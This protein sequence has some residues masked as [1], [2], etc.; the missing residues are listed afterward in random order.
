MCILFIY[1]VS[2]LGLCVFI[3]NQFSSIIS[4]SMFYASTIHIK[5]ENI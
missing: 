2:K 3:Y 1:F 5:S 4:N